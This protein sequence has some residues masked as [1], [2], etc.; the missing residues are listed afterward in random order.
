MKLLTTNRLGESDQTSWYQLWEAATA[1]W[2][3]CVVKGYSGSFRGLDLREGV[4][5][6][7]AAGCAIPL[8]SYQKG[9]STPA[10]VQTFVFTPAKIIDVVNSSTFG[11]FSSAFRD[12]K[13]VS[14]ALKGSGLL[15]VDFEMD[16]P[17]GYVLT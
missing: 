1:V 14:F 5:R 11:K 4:V 9:S 16:N 12:L 3:K 15:E 6:R 7:T 8:S 2:Y 10:A 17:E 13:S